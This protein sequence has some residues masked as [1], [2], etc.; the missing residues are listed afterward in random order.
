MR[1][2]Y[3]LVLQFVQVGYMQQTI[4]NVTDLFSDLYVSEYMEYAS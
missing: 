3:I 1:K 4:A 2:T